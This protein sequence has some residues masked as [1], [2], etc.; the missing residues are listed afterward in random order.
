MRIR[1][2]NIASKAERDKWDLQFN[3]ITKDIKWAITS[4]NT[5]PLTGSPNHTPGWVGCTTRS[6]QETP[7]LW[8]AFETLEPLLWDLAPADRLHAQFRIANTCVHELAHAVNA[9]I[10]P[11]NYQLMR[12][13]G[14]DR[15]TINTS[16]P[17]FE[18]DAISELG[19]SAEK[20]VWGGRMETIA[21][22]GEGPLF[23]ILG[24][25]LNPG[26][27]IHTYP[28]EKEYN[29]ALAGSDI[30]RTTGLDGPKVLNSELK[31]CF[32]VVTESYPIPIY[33]YATIQKREF[34]EGPFMKYGPEV[35]SAWQWVTLGRRGP[36]IEMEYP[37]RSGDHNLRTPHAFRHGTNGGPPL[38]R[39]I[40]PPKATN[41]DELI[42]PAGATP[43]QIFE[44]QMETNRRGKAAAINNAFTNFHILKA[45]NQPAPGPDQ[46]FF[47][48]PLPPTTSA[49]M[50]MPPGVLCPRFPEIFGF[51]LTH[52]RTLAVHTMHVFLEP[53]IPENTLWHYIQNIKDASGKKAIDLSPEEF[54]CFCRLPE[55]QDGIVR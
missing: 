44:T 28:S 31:A 39:D 36:D 25:R 10:V 9:A 34:W 52:W 29:S 16:E 49:D 19:A 40:S 13:P 37:L 7:L 42:Q 30:T 18:N 24:D 26:T 43:A 22:Q 14:P 38:Y 32:N 2:R 21:T 55:C 50:L 12:H 5:T 51:W 46:N 11:E 3:Q 17:F 35:L 33:Y 23:Q 27:V 4:G 54:R 20:A 48:G 8:L 15:A 53:Q 47:Q 6:D 45:N 41:F 1:R